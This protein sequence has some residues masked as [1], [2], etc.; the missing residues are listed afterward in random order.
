MKGLIRKILFGDTVIKE[1][2][3]VTTGTKKMESVYLEAGHLFIDVSDRQ[4]VFC[5]T[6]VVFGIWIEDNTEAT[7]IG[8][9]DLFNLYFSDAPLD[10]QRM[11]A[12][13]AMAIVQLARGHKICDAQGTLFLFT[14]LNVRMRHVAAIKAH[15]LYRRY[16]RKPG[17]SFDKLKSLVAAYSYPR[18]VRVI[19]F[20][21]DDYY[22]IFPM[23][24]LGDLSSH[25]RYVFGLRHTNTTLKR[26]ISTGKIVVSDCSHEWKGTIYELGKHHGG[27]PPPL[28]QLPFQTF[29]SKQFGFDVPMWVD[30]YKEIEIVKTIDLGSHML[31]WGNCVSYETLKPPS[32][33]LYHVHFL[34]TLHQL[35]AGHAY[36]NV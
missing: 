4:W 5:L 11:A 7:I 23:D 27:S 22:N 35:S 32:D 10:D 19:S 6:P 3:T 29:K 18:R 16:Y 24:L 13:K 28:K 36:T 2:S 33:G 1:Y 9:A 12:R 25:N 34:L 31:M 15:I 8:N 14:L 26:I 20:R 21:E 17:L 30:N